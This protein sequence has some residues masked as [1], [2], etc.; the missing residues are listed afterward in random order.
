ML[1]VLAGDADA[2]AGLAFVPWQ[3]TV[4]CLG[5]AVEG[6][7]EQLVAHLHVEDGE[8]LVVRAAGK[9]ARPRMPWGRLGLLRPRA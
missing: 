8:M 9:T 1:H 4:H 2:K 3:E 7:M 6:V 5:I